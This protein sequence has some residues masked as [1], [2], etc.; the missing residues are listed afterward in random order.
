MLNIPKRTDVNTQIGKGA[1]YL[2]QVGTLIQKFAIGLEGIIVDKVTLNGEAKTPVVFGDDVYAELF[3]DAVGED[4]HF[5]I[6]SDTTVTF[7]AEDNKVYIEEDSAGVADGNDISIEVEDGDT[8]D[9]T[10]EVGKFRVLTESVA[11]TTAGEYEFLFT[12]LLESGDKIKVSGDGI[13][14]IEIDFDTT[15][16]GDLEI[17]VGDFDDIPGMVTQIVTAINTQSAGGQIAENM[18]ATAEGFKRQITFATTGDFISDLSEATVDE[19]VAFM[20]NA[21]EESGEDDEYWAEAVGEGE[22]AQIRVYNLNSEMTTAKL[23]IDE[24]ADENSTL[25]FDENDIQYGQQ[26][27]GEEGEFNGDY[28]IIPS[29]MDA[30]TGQTIGIDDIE[31][32]GFSLICSTTSKTYDMG[33][34]V[35]GTLK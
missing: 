7:T 32:D 4:G 34:V 15:G 30:E 25:G 3:S 18:T 1:S 31:S 20:Q 29:I 17:D 22:E 9:I 5:D 24:N 11:G 13:T 26:G 10:E 23:T 21:I 14:N 2:P 28:V 8:E 6:S 12:S 33:L 16:A 19:I 35:L 27:I